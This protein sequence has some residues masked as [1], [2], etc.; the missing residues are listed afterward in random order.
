M[1][2][3]REGLLLTLVDPVVAT[4]EAASAGRPETLTYLPGAMLLG[5]F[6]A[7]NYSKFDARNLAFEV[8]HSGTVRFGDALPLDDRGHIGFPVPASLHHPKHLY[9]R[10]IRGAV[11]FG[12][13]RRGD[14]QYKQLRDKEITTSGDQIDVA[15]VAAMKTA[16]DPATGRAAEAQLFGIEALA[17]GQR[18]WAEVSADD[19]T[20]LADVKASIPD[21]SMLRLGRSRATEYGRVRAKWT[22]APPFPETSERSDQGEPRL[23]W[24]LSDIVLDPEANDLS[25]ALG[26]TGA[27]LDTERCFIRQR[28]VWPY[29]GYWG[30]RGQEHLVAQ[31]GSV[32]ALVEGGPPAGPGFAGLHRAIGCGRILTEPSFLNAE[33]FT[34]QTPCLGLGLDLSSAET[35]TDDCSGDSTTFDLLAARRRR[36]AIG[37]EREAFARQ[38]LDELGRLYFDAA[39]LAGEDA[40]WVGPGPSQWSAVRSATVSH[41]VSG[42]LFGA[43]KGLARAS[44]R[45]WGASVG[46]GE[47]FHIWLK[48]LHSKS[49]EDPESLALVAKGASEAVAGLRQDGTWRV[50]L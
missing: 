50:R 17:V 45:V 10:D 25:T 15:R 27:Q 46:P 31:R 8:F 22:S 21:G 11:N 14:V 7:R 16:I 44:D 9:K 1:S 33:E 48:N 2:D 18:F 39:D 29:N 37:T 47:S 30:T 43:E 28:R 38:A 13:A 49:A 26:L 5:A 32:I 4:A 20:L 42:A 19:P 41:D 23:I 12:R 24:A 34:P 36:T 40:G 3:L 35:T 6:A